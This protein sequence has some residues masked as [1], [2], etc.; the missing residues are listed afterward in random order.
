MVKGD[1]KT[2]ASIE[3]VPEEGSDEEKQEDE[4]NDQDE[5]KSQASGINIEGNEE[6][7]EVNEKDPDQ[8]T[9]ELEKNK[10]AKKA[11]KSQDELKT[12]MAALAKKTVDFEPN[13]EGVQGLV[14]F[15]K[16]NAEN[17]LDNTQMSCIFALMFSPQ[18]I[19][20]MAMT[21]LDLKRSSQKSSPEMEELAKEP[22]QKWG[23]GAW[24]KGGE[25]TATFA[26]LHNF[27][28]IHVQPRLDK[29]ATSTEKSISAVRKNLVE[30]LTKD[31]TSQET[32]TTQ[33][34]TPVSATNY[35]V[36]V[37]KGIDSEPM[38]SA[39]SS[40]SD[41][42]AFAEEV[43][44]SLKDVA[45]KGSMRAKNLILYI[46]GSN[47]TSVEE[48]KSTLLNQMAKTREAGYTMALA[49]GLTDEEYA[50]LA[51]ALNNGKQRG[52]LLGGNTAS[53]D[54]KSKFGDKAKVTDAKSGSSNDAKGDSRKSDHKTAD[55]KQCR[56]CGIVTDNHGVDAS[57]CPYV[58]QKHPNA[59][60]STWPWDKSK[61]GKDAKSAGHDQLPW[62]KLI[63]G[64]AFQML[65][66]QFKPIGKSKR[67]AEE[68]EDGKSTTTKGM[69]TRL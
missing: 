44:E 48:W 23:S 45:K 60:T 56:G 28:E 41:Q 63:D 52:Q 37:W 65:S 51:V 17:T 12:I 8:E 25:N 27:L 11:K 6:D 18:A 66:N 1:K 21:I 39:I 5:E 40:A 50:R 3:P 68:I 57:K 4:D 13:Q 43:M 19:Q 69:S 62:A 49:Y 54:Q 61:A 35:L 2:K 59:N 24:H 10:S 9:Q 15:L 58:K 42:Q 22:F 14:R 33:N 32:L 7:G 20:W 55:K 29:A 36:E 30:K 38:A 53:Q 31:I 26:Q 47:P 64:T 16:A 67:L 46:D 34:R